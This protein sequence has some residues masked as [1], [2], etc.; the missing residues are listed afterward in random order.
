MALMH[1]LHMTHPPRDVRRLAALWLALLVPLAGLA[2]YALGGTGAA[3]VSLALCLAGG[4]AVLWGLSP[5]RYPHARLG[6]CNATTMTRAA[7]VAVLAGLLVAPMAAEALGWWLV[8]LA[9][10][11]LALDGV[12][13][14]A[15]RRSGL[16]S[17]F[18]ARFDVETDVVF[19][20]V[21]AALAVALGQV[22]AWFL[23]LGFMRPL[24]LLAARVMPWV[25][26]PLPPTPRRKG[27]AAAQMTAQVVLITPLLAPP[28]S[29]VLGAAILATVLLSF[30]AD[31]R[32]LWAARG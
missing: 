8:A 25:G 22:G 16:R 6:L 23:L 28:E 5:R 18:G 7:G 2:S 15:A 9:G 11:V 19:A 26:A 29:V 20:L 1:P 14:W 17:D 21:M 13:G 32:A 3:A 10:G 24:F 4:G 31:I 30:A 12:D 27:V